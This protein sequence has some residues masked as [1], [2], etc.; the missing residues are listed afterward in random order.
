[1]SRLQYVLQAVPIL[2]LLRG[3]PR[4]HY[5]HIHFS[6]G[7]GIYALYK[8]MDAIA[9]MSLTVCRQ[10]DSCQ[11]LPLTPKSLLS[12]TISSVWTCMT[13]W[14]SM[15]CR[16]VDDFQLKSILQAVLIPPGPG[17]IARAKR[18]SVW[19]EHYSF[20]KLF[21]LVNLRNSSKKSSPFVIYLNAL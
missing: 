3:S 11:A 9:A 10:E 19:Q 7:Y 4:R 15:P 17:C 20:T 6:Y 18:Q 12:H 13:A 2:A 8:H 14:A 16:H 5:T 21:V 1:M